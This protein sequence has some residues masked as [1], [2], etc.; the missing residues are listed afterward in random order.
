[1][2][3]TALPLNLMGLTLAGGPEALIDTISDWLDGELFASVN[4]HSPEPSESAGAA[5]QH[6][7][8]LAQHV[9]RGVPAA[10]R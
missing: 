5:P 7:G 3:L 1:M 4:A 9:A 8:L 6:S 10:K 2:E